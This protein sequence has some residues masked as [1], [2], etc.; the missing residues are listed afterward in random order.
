MKK[1]I[2][3]V[4]FMI[5]AI[6]SAQDYSSTISA[7]LNNNT[8]KLNLQE[9]DVQE[10]KI[11]SSAYSQSMKL[12]VVH[13]SQKFQGVEIANTSSSFALKN[14]VVVNA[15]LSFENNLQRKI[16]GTTPSLNAATAV[17]RAASAL[18]MESPQGLEVLETI[19]A[20]SFVFND[21]GI[22]NDNIPVRLIYHKNDSE[23]TL[24]WE[25][26]I[27]TQDGSHYYLAIIDA[28]SGELIHQGDLVLSC[29][30]GET[31]HQH[32]ANKKEIPSILF[33]QENTEST[34]MVDGSQYRVFPV[35]V[36]SP[37]H[38]SSSLVIEPADPV[39]SP[40]GWHDTNG[41]TGAEFTITRGNNVY[42][43]EDF[44]GDGSTFGDAPDGG[45]DLDF[46]FPQIL[47]TAPRNNIEGATVN[48]FYWNNI[49][50]DIWYQY[51]F[52]EASGNFQENNYGNGGTGSDSVIA[53][54]QDGAG[55]NNASFFPPGDG[56]NGRMNMFLWT[57]PA[58]TSEPLTI[59]NGPLAGSYEATTASFGAP[60][61][62]ASDPII[63]TLALSLDDDAGTSTDPNDACDNIT[64]EAALAGNIAVIRRGTCEF[65]VKML[66][67]ENAGAIA[68]IVVTDDRPIGPM[69]PG[70]VG[71]QVTIPSIMIAQDTGEAI[72]AALEN[73][74]T[75]NVSLN[76]DGPFQKDG[77]LDNGIIAHEYGHG[78]STRLTGGRFNPGCLQNLEQM[79]EGWS[80]WFGLM[81][82]IQ[83]GQ[84]GTDARGIGT[85]VTNQTTTGSG[86]RP[87]RYSTDFTVNPSTYA[88]IATYSN[89]ESPHRTGYVWATML[90]D[91]NW[92][93]VDQYGFDEDLYN[94]T[95]GNNIV[96]QL[97]MD[98]LK[99]QG[100]SPG[101]V[102][103]RDA[104]LQADE[105]IN[106][107]ANRCLIWETFARRGL[108]ASADQGSVND[109]SDGTQ[110]FDVPTG[111]DCTL[112]TAEN[113]FDNNFRIYPNP[114]NGNINISSIVALDDANVSIFDINGRQVYSNDMS[115]QDTVNINAGSL[116][117]GVYVLTISNDN[118]THTAKIIIE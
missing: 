37:I 90:W 22:S 14:G 86:I 36:E 69:G 45:S 95:G 39:A 9:Q 25:V 56:Q 16:S 83:P 110:A 104:I 109:R 6:V 35:P 62:M 20:N 92:A 47:E 51:G 97:V 63:G 112:G 61:P 1:I 84:D 41:A 13:V 68:A 74:E 80:D 33:P 85:F 24:S 57:A 94:G 29:N 73:G 7:Y 38:G 43:Q 40:F 53:D 99:L 105:L 101:F 113:N 65:G 103:G 64:N 87:T 107:G 100:C 67:V 76:E 49:M 23:L 44:D 55:L 21:G 17:S 46:D 82:T 12:D 52:D 8:S 42:A 59:T 48:L 11:S 66:A 27:Y 34:M 75:I 3:F 4:T 10:I 58:G 32:S 71:N 115:I 18:E 102:D 81:I 2:Y 114:S 26:G 98:G 50:H 79:G 54:A 108:G 78:I 117:S 93:F 72:I 89:N 88:T 5:T 28:I 116:T 15:S 77:S 70:D 96:M 118:F 111:P 30:F 31:P 60:L 19:D 106:G 91:L